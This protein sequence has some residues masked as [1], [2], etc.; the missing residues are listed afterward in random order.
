[1]SISCFTGACPRYR[2]AAAFEVAVDLH[3]GDDGAEVRGHRLVECQQAEAAVVDVD[4]QAVDRFVAGEHGVEQRMIAGD[5]PLDGRAH[6]F[7]GEAAHLEQ[8][9]LERFELLLEMPNSL[10]H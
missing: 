10:F 2:A 7:F 6:P 4:V 1:M 3:G 9:P 5:K 8:P